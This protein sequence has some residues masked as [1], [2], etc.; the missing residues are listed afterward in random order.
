ML[1]KK[2]RKRQ[3]N[4]KVPDNLDPGSFASKTYLMLKIMVLNQC[5][6]SQRESRACV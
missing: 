3:A 2:M 1:K 6:T 5:F 4:L